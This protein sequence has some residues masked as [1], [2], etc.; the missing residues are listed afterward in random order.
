MQRLNRLALLVALW[1]GCSKPH[2]GDPEAPPS[3][4]EDPETPP[5]CQPVPGPVV[6]HA[7]PLSSAEFCTAWADAFCAYQATCSPAFE[8]EPAASCVERRLRSCRLVFPRIADEIAAGRLAWSDQ[9]AGDCV[10]AMHDGT[11]AQGTR[12]P[13]LLTPAASVGTTC[14]PDAPWLSLPRADRTLLAQS[15]DWP[16]ECLEG[17]CGGDTCPGTCQPLGDED[18]ECRNPGFRPMVPCGKDLYCAPFMDH[19]VDIGLSHCLRRLGEGGSCT[20]DAGCLDGLYCH[21]G[22]CEPQVS[23]CQA[24]DLD[25]ACA[26]GACRDGVCRRANVGEGSPCSGRSCDGELVCRCPDGAALLPNGAPAC[27][28]STGGTPGTVG[29]CAR[30]GADGAPCVND[31][32][33]ARGLTCRSTGTCGAPGGAEASC[34]NVSATS[35]TPGDSDA[36]SVTYSPDCAAGLTC[37]DGRCTARPGTGDACTWSVEG[38]TCYAPGLTCTRNPAND[39]GVCLTPSAEGTAC[40]QV[41]GCVEGYY[42]NPFTKTCLPYAATGTDCEA[43]AWQC[44]DRCPKLGPD[45]WTCQPFCFP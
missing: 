31:W 13:G 4:Q 2:H 34:R 3:G 32:E 35:G 43:N 30:P 42:C 14:R 8:V 33:C 41:R 28:R 26:D 23:Q 12:C 22:S 20:L 16:G 21:G 9:V 17:W 5:T 18:V 1:S 25:A 19:D 27:P 45:R 10:A 40:D 38:G 11:C 15:L 24:C 37:V 44:A 36:P 7:A 39:S 6:V 29:V